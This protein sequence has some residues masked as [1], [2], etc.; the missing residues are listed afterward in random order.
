M[1]WT[2]QFNYIDVVRFN[3]N[4]QNSKVC[5]KCI[6]TSNNSVVITDKD[7]CEEL[8]EDYQGGNVTDLNE[9]GF[10]DTIFGKYK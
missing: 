6:N 5:K 3:N 1:R 8:G 2:D 9:I 7:S 10:H 4:V